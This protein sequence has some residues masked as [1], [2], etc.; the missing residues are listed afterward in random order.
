MRVHSVDACKYV[1]GQ[2]ET[3]RDALAVERALQISIN[4]SPYTVTMR[5]PSDDPYL[6][7]GLL[8]TEGL[9]PRADAEMTFDCHEGTMFECENAINVVLSPE[10][11]ARDDWA[12][13]RSMVS[14]SSCGVCGTRDI[15]DLNILTLQP[16][17]RAEVPLDISR[18][19]AMTEAMRKQQSSFEKTGGCHGAAAFDV[20]G[21]VLCVFEDVGRHNAVDKVI[22]CLMHHRQLSEVHVL[23]VSGRVSYEIVNKAYVA[24]IS[25]LLAVS[26][27]SSLAVH[28]SNERGI[29]LIGFCRDGRATVYSHDENIEQSIAAKDQKLCQRI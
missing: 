28:L 13:S 24:G 16:P 15:R 17:L 22:G 12:S 2:R 6:V 19:P 20:E 8:Y 1:F 27:P 7:R 9:V 29:T 25:F 11:L 4:D 10:E 21:R 23:H 18:I 26:A 14:N 3:V 5:T